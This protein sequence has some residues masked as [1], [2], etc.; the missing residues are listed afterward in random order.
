MLNAKLPETFEHA[1][2]MMQ[3]TKGL[4]MNQQD[5]FIATHALYELQP[6]E[7]FKISTRQ[8]LPSRWYVEFPQPYMRYMQ[9]KVCTLDLVD[10]SLMLK[11]AEEPLNVLLPTFHSRC[12]PTGKWASPLGKTG[13]S[14]KELRRLRGL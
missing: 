14:S 12:R 10:Q 5:R 4:A 7:R 9:S 11:K 8:K 3:H 2:G 13:V 1:N 6:E